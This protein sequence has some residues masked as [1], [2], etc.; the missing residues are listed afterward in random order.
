M[1][2]TY[3]SATAGCND[4]AMMPLCEWKYCA[5]TQAV[6]RNKA[7]ILAHKKNRA[8]GRTYPLAHR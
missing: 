5:K 3:S 6:L 4:V 2:K 1:R 7:I 8:C